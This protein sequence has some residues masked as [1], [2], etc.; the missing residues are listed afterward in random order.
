M[1]RGQFVADDRVILQK[2]AAALKSRP[3]DFGWRV[4]ITAI[5]VEH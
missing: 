2:K 3:F 1:V 4:G 5:E